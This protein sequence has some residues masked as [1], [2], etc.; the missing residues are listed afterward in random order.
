LLIFAWAPWLGLA[1]AAYLLLSGLRNIV[2]P[3]T[4]A[5]VNQRLD[6]DVRATVL[7]LVGQ[8]DAFGQIAGGPVV[9]WLA[10]AVSVSLALSA[11]AALLTPAL[12][13]IARANQ[14]IRSEDRL[15]SPG[16]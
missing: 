9:G 4:D 8:V 13:L 3:L 6:A 16:D 5:W 2:G 12:G 11:S 15:Q 10:K 14:R 7:S 1:L